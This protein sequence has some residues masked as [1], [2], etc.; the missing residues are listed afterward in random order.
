MEEA[1]QEDKE[2]EMESDRTPGGSIYQDRSRSS[3]G[4]I[5][6]PNRTSHNS[7]QNLPKD[8][9]AQGSKEKAQQLSSSAQQ[10]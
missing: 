2:Q 3:Q 8:Q 10:L 6:Q 1:S 4:A 5:A 9:L 7:Q